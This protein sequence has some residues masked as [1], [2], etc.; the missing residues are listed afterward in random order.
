MK[1]VS[2]P[3]VV[4]H[5]R[6]SRTSGGDAASIWTGATARELQKELTRKREDLDHGNWDTLATATHH[7]PASTV[8]I[9]GRILEAVV[10]PVR[11][12]DAPTPSKTVAS[13]SHAPGAKR[14][15]PDRAGLLA[16]RGFEAEPHPSL[17][18]EPVL[19]ARPMT[20]VKARTEEPSASRPNYRKRRRA[21][22]EGLPVGER[23]KRGLRGRGSTL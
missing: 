1:R 3:F 10:P 9:A 4:E 12:N 22:T 5:K 8:P 20:C 19:I 7:P 14:S 11:S 17:T 2:K 16:K 15:H 18:V 21:A 13:P 23:W 6:R